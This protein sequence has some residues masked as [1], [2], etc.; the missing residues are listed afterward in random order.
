ML[1]CSPFA[2]K[3]LSRASYHHLVSPTRPLSPERE[4]DGVRGVGSALCFYA[5]A[6]CDPAMPGMGT[7]SGVCRQ[8][9]SACFAAWLDSSFM[10]RRWYAAGTVS[11]CHANDGPGMLSRSTSSAGSLLQH[12]L[13]HDR[14][15]IY[16]EAFVCCG[17]GIQDATPMIDRDMLSLSKSSYASGQ[18]GVAVSRGEAMSDTDPL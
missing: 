17:N 12:A 13:R 18:E 15:V 10:A 16:G 2:P 9:A 4:R 6:N 3:P 1:W 8:L 11:R 5:W 14:L 7:S